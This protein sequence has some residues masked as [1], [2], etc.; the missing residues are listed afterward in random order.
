MVAGDLHAGG[1]ENRRWSE[2]RFGHGH[3]QK[4]QCGMQND[5]ETMGMHGAHTCHRYL[6]HGGKFQEAAYLSNRVH[7]RGCQESATKKETY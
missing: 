2:M 1:N 4:V 6:F 5:L 3:H 7:S